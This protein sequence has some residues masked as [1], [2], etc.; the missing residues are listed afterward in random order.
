MQRCVRRE[1]GQG[2][3]LMNFEFA[4]SGR[5]LFGPG[6]LRELG[7]I[8]ASLGTRALVV[9]GVRGESRAS[10]EGL[11]MPAGVAAAAPYF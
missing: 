5:I 4:T 2:V 9:G 7:P 6:R 1:T 11:L 3:A 10:V 8:V